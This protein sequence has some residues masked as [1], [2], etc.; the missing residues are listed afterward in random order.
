[1]SVIDQASVSVIKAQSGD[2]GVREQLIS[3][4]MSFIRRTVRHLTHAV[5][6]DQMDEFSIALSAFNEAIDRYQDEC[7]VPFE[8]YARILI[9]HRLTDW[10]R[11]QKNKIQTFSLSDQASEDTLPLEERL[12]DPR[13]DLVQ[14]NL[15]FEESLLRLQAQLENMGLGLDDLVNRFPKHRDTRLLCIRLA[16]C[17][18]SNETLY[19]RLAQSGRLP[20]KD[21]SQSCDVP[22]KTIERNRPAIILLA[23]LLKSDLQMI[24]AYIDRYE[25]E[26]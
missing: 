11:S 6:V 1:M 24:Q 12:T 20:G 13:S 26:D 10:Y 9:K 18:V 17:L 2:H 5:F 25:R 14:T 16:R 7:R 15:E 3:D 21:L 4:H 23:L 22:Q 8:Q 19:D